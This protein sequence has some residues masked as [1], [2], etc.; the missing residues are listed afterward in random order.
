[1]CDSAKK[2]LYAEDNGDGTTTFTINNV[3]NENE[4]VS[5]IMNAGITD[6]V[7]GF[8]S[9]IAPEGVETFESQATFIPNSPSEL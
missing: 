3:V 1:M 9:Y 4:A 8:G 7:T 2:Y 5:F 6:L